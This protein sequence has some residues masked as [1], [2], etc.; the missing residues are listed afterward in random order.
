[1]SHTLRH[2]LFTRLRTRL[3]HI[4][5]RFSRGLTMGAQGCVLDDQARVFLI[6]HTYVPG[7]HFP[8]GG[9]ETGETILEA[10]TR[11]LH[12]E[13]NL[14]LTQPPRLFSLYYN[15]ALSKRDHIALFIVRHFTQTEPRLADYEIAEARF[16]ALD[17]LP[18]TLHP[19]TRRRL[20]EILEHQP[21]SAIW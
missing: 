14:T 8:G 13:A 19:A 20:K 11:E 15:R 7:W 9:V 12:E 21:P 4:Y 3:F 17:D 1:M 18:A 6:R 5:F 10:L 2:S 16:F